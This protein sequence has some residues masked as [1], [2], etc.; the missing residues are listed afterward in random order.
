MKAVVFDRYGPPESLRL[1][2]TDVPEPAEGQVRIRVRAASLNA[3]DW[4]IYR[5]DPWIAKLS[6]G[7]RSPGLRGLGADVA[8]VVDAVG[9]GV[10][11]FAVG[12]DVFGEIGAGAVADFALAEQSRIALKPSSLNYEEAAALPMAALTAYQGLRDA[13]VKNGAGVLVI[14]ASGGVGHMAVQIARA[15]GA[16]RVVAVCSGR[17]ADW[18]AEIGADRVIDYT[19][20]SVLDADERFDVVYDTVATTS[21]RKLRKVMWPDA[22]YA[23]AGAVG[24]SALLGPAG[25]MFRSVGS[26]WFISQ[27][28]ALVQAKP[29][30]EDLKAIAEMVDSGKVRPVIYQVYAMEDFAAALTK[31]E[32]KHTAGK[33]VLAVS[34]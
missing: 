30:G 21:V 2:D 18:V 20:E 17:N 1:I 19:Q 22:V 24:G 3:Y 13:P 4:H 12:D 23:P 33:L 16:G 11:D 8:G 28:V 31:L 25:P 26:G 29:S 34:P 9:P 5:G 15:L 7:L 32:G 27:R 10:T 14:G 6:F